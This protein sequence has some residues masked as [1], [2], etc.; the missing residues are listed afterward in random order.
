MPRTVLGIV[1]VKLAAVKLVKFAPE[2][3]PNKPDQVPVPIVPTEVNELSVVT[4]ELT[5]VPVV[6][7]V[8]LVVP[9]V[10]IV[11]L[12]PPIVNKLEL[13]AKPIVA[14]VGVN[15]I[16]LILVAV[17]EPKLGVT[18]DGLLDSTTSP[19]PVFV[20]T[21]VPPDVTGNALVNANDGIV[22]V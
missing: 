15:A 14:V 21:P 13:L 9:V 11:V 10:V 1:P 5:N 16:P 12:Y 18:N 6:G 20:V 19:V 17:A 4:A 2:T 7:N 22:T 3:D 8:I